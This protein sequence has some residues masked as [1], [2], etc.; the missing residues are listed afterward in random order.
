MRGRILAGTLVLSM[1]FFAWKFQS[2]SSG[3]AV[4]G[5]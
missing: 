2:G 5:K 3:T 1:V 4:R